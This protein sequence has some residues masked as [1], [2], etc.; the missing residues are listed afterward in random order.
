MSKKS[1]SP[2]E[3][4]RISVE[5]EQV[6]AALIIVSEDDEYIHAYKNDGMDVKSFNSFYF[7]L[8]LQKSCVFCGVVAVSFHLFK[9]KINIGDFDGVKVYRWKYFSNYLF[10]KGDFLKLNG[11]F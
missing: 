10:P 3:C 9:F 8:C 5:M 11:M 2:K 6:S 4:C 7:F 1:D